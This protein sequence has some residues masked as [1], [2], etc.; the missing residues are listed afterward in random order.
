M[1]LDNLFN[2]IKLKESSA[3]P[4]RDEWFLENRRHA[5]E[6]MKTG[7]WTYEIGKDAVYFTDEYYHILETAPEKLEKNAASYFDYVAKEDV[8]KV[9]TAREQ[10]YQGHDQELEYQLITGRGNVKYVKEKTRTLLDEI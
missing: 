1:A 4:E 2:R 10:A 9:R 3:L 6:M 7:S 5:Q 8:S